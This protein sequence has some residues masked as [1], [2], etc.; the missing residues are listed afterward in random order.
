MQGS[1]PLRASSGDGLAILRRIIVNRVQ[2]D[3]SIEINAHLNASPVTMD[4]RR[5]QAGL[6]DFE[7][8]TDYALAQS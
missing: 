3:R 4:F 5:R 1:W 7:S 6:R 8:A 2:I